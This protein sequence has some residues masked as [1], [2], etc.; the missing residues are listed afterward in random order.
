MDFRPRAGQPCPRAAPSFAL[1]GRA[2]AACRACALV[3]LVLRGYALEINKYLMISAP[4]LGK[5]VYSKVGGDKTTHPLIEGGVLRSPQGLAVDHKQKWLFVADPD[6]RKI[7]FFKLL[8]NNGVVMVNGEPGTAAQN[9]E[10]RWVAIDGVGNM[11]FTDERNNLIQRV[12]AEKLRKGDP[13]PTVLYNGIDVASVSAPGG[14]AADNFRL[15]WTNK[16]VG[17][18]VGSVARGYEYPPETNLA[19]S[20][21]PITK[22]VAKSYGVCLVMDNVY[23]TDADS[24]VYAVKKDGGAITTVTDKMLQPRGCAWDGDGTV[25]IA[26]KAGDAVY[27][28][29][30]N[31]HNLRPTRLT[32]AVDFEDSFGVAVISGARRHAVQLA[33]LIAALSVARRGCA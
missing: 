9:V 33:M 19:S 22:N 7:F 25:F 4:R 27:S 10:S 13:T 23:Y 24:T 29:A 11:F 20:V 1:M 2:A 15:F 17:Q 21:R 5:V 18:Q 32:K 26:D 30:G 3:A 28:F 14:I 31:M 6:A 12:S 8:F 16:A